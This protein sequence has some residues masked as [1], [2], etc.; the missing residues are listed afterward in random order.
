MG[1]LCVCV[2]SVNV[3]RGYSSGNSDPEPFK[4]ALSCAQRGR[5][6]KTDTI[7]SVPGR[8]VCETFKRRNDIVSPLISLLLSA[9]SAKSLQEFAAVL[10]NLE[11]ERTRMV[12]SKHI[13]IGPVWSRVQMSII[14]FPW[15]E[16]DQLCVCL[17]VCVRVCLVLILQIENANDVLIMP[18]ERFRK[19]QISAAKVRRRLCSHQSK[20]TRAACS[21]Q[22][23]ISQSIRAF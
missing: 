18:L 16:T 17:C 12:S 10:Q 13:P 21:C 9:P 1:I 14:K 5:A 4:P 6:V 11:D 22:S 2:S 19:E 3:D 15:A 23:G 7:T 8:D 20:G